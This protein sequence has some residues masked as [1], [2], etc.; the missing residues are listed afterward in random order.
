VA[1]HD[2]EAGD[3]NGNLGLTIRMGGEVY[4]VAQKEHNQQKADMK[5]DAKKDLV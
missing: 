3:P 2:E 1:W 5:K 4:N